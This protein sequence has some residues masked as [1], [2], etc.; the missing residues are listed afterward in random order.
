MA[1]DSEGTDIEGMG[2][3][4]HI[5]LGHLPT[6]CEAFDLGKELTMFLKNFAYVYHSDDAVL[7]FLMAVAN[8]LKAGKFSRKNLF[9]TLIFLECLGQPMGVQEINSMKVFPDVTTGKIGDLIFDRYVSHAA[10]RLI[11]LAMT[12]IRTAN[13]YGILRLRMINAATHAL[14]VKRT[15][16]DSKIVRQY[17]KEWEMAELHE[18]FP[19]RPLIFYKAFRKN[20]SLW[21]GPGHQD[22]H[23]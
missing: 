6:V 18:A 14:Q 17:L 8:A 7:R 10:S 1:K 9:D 13:S 22:L 3:A 11:S 4:T 20:P 12:T 16:K 15:I 21:K 2:F 23:H 5:G 19:N